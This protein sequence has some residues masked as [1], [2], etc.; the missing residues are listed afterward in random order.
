MPRLDLK[1][2][3]DGERIRA[4]LAGT[5]GG[6]TVPFHFKT[7]TFY[8]GTEWSTR[9]PFPPNRPLGMRIRDASC[10]ESLCFCFCFILISPYKIM[11][12]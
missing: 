2:N 9:L 7:V 6:L 3:Q 12:S 8:E 1:E 10:I 4:C 5:E 11:V